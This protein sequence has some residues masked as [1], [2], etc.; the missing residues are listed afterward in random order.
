MF[1]VSHTQGVCHA[2]Y[3]FKDL[4]GSIFSKLKYQVLIIHGEIASGKTQRGE[5]I[6]NRARTK[7]YSVHG[8]LSKRVI[9]NRDTIGYD[10][11]DLQSGKSQP[12]VYKDQSGE[13]WEPLRGPFS[14]KTCAFAEANKLLKD[15]AYQM[16]PKTL[17]IADEF[18]HLEA[19]GFGIYPGLRKIVDALGE[20]KLMILCRTDKI[21][22]VLRLFNQNETRI[23]VMEA[24]QKDFMDTLA[25][26]FI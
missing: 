11:V 23:L 10:M 13:E 17:V 2:L 1:E 6:A 3:R 18:G 22:A 16:D 14:F 4:T 12:M 5:Q 19:R 20:G 9:E 21:D 25:D 8:I 24:V 7:G 15:A 26:S